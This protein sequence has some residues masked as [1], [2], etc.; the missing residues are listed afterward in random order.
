MKK[1]RKL[2]SKLLFEHPRHSVYEDEVELPSG[3]KTT[4]LHFG[5]SVDSATVIALNEIGHV[6]LQKEYSY[7]SNEWLYQFPGGG[8]KKGE[9]PEAGALR[10]LSEEADIHGSLK[11]I[12]WFYP[13]NRRKPSKM[14][15]FVATNLVAQPGKKDDEEVFET[16]WLSVEELETLIKN[17]E[18]VNYS[19]LAA[20]S[21]Y[22]VSL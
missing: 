20:W 14:H 11:K 9:S 15:V 7:P 5:N 1:W 19:T 6:L 13:D 8:L 2:S 4:Y 10:E 16:F 17:G 22:K 21:L 3:R 18:I 12:G